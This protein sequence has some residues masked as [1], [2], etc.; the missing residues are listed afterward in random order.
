MITVTPNRFSASAGRLGCLLFP[1]VGTVTVTPNR[2]SASA[3]R[4]GDFSFPLRGEFYR[5]PEPGFR[6][7]GAVG[8]FAVFAFGGMITVAPNRTS[9]SAGRLGDFF[10]SLP[11]DDYRDPEPDF[12]IGGAVGGVCCFFLRGLFTAG[13]DYC[14]SCF[15]AALAAAFSA[16]LRFCSSR[17]FLRRLR[18]ASISIF[19]T[20]ARS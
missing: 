15:W 3:G 17:W 1:P 2:T 4:L 7:S 18:R 19:S 16:F 20:V 8:V 12:R 14:F 10:F 9:A 11:W 5:D 13:W 6:I